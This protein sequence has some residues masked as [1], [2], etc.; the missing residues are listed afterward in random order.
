M[1]CSRSPGEIEDTHREMGGAGSRRRRDSFSR[2]H[3]AVLV[4]DFPEPEPDAEVKV[5]LV[6]DT[7]RLEKAA[8]MECFVDCHFN[9]ALGYQLS[10]WAPT[11]HT[12]D[13]LDVEI[14]LWGLQPATHRHSRT[15]TTDACG[16]AAR[17]EAEFRRRVRDF[18][19]RAG[20]VVLV[21]SVHDRASFEACRAHCAEAREHAPDAV[22]VC[23]GVVGARV[24]DDASEADAPDEADEAPRVVGEAEAR[25]LCGELEVEYF[26]VDVRVDDGRVDTL[27]VGLA[28][29]VVDRQ[30]LEPEANDNAR[31]DW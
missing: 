29:A 12:I 8:L 27:F 18:Y 20:G 26:E 30:G 17:T 13:D 16:T 19:T 10:D 9:R 14:V 24:A 31:R 4:E 23:C 22:V 5:L 15:L 2:P 11:R 28:R 6:G 7:P 21:F 1:L 3:R 25:A